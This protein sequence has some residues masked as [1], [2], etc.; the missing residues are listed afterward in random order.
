MTYDNIKSHKKTGFHP[1]YRRYIFQ[2]ATKL[3]LNVL[4]LLL[5]HFVIFYHFLDKIDSVLRILTV[6]KIPIIL[7]PITI[8]NLTYF[9]MLHVFFVLF[10]NFSIL[11]E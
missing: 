9:I 1:P 4:S 10:L 6:S 8:Y 2:R 3:G 7:I 5:P 11:V